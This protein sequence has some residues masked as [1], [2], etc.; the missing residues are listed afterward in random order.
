MR[1]LVIDDSRMMQA[2]MK[3]ALARAG[4]EVILAGDGKAGLTKA[5]QMHPSLILLDMMLPIMS[6]PEVLDALK[7]D[8]STK[9]IPVFVLTGLSQQNEAKLL[10]AGAVK[11]FEK[12][13]LFVENNFAELIEAV[14]EYSRQLVQSRHD[15]CT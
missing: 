6:G 10:H 2:G 3:R 12:S 7:M 14:A 4:H 15:G 8:P 1:V 13:E 9:E 11:Y 5:L